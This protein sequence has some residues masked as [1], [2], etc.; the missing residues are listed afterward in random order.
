MLFYYKILLWFLICRESLFTQFVS[1]FIVSRYWWYWLGCLRLYRLLFIALDRYL[2]R[3]FSLSV[4]A[5]SLVCLFALFA[6]L[7]MV[8]LFMLAF[9]LFLMFAYLFALLLFTWA[10]TDY[11]DTIF[12]HITIEIDLLDSSCALY[13][14]IGFTGWLI[15]CWAGVILTRSTAVRR[16]SFRYLTLLIFWITTYNILYNLF[17]YC[18]SLTCLLY[19]GCP[20]LLLLRLLAIHLLLFCFRLNV[21]QLD[22]WWRD[23]NVKIFI[24]ICKL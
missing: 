12:L 6:F 9:L 1:S 10:E 7:L 3:S 2:R 11:L 18:F 13:W 4:L 8:V 22:W 5:I 14:A 17:R 15:G 20:Y 21:H 24:E 19:Q 23:W 16:V